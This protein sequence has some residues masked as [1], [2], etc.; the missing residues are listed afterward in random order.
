MMSFLHPTVGSADISSMNHLLI[1]AEG[2]R[3]SEMS[4]KAWDAGLS[5]DAQMRPRWI[6]TYGMLTRM[7]VF[8]VPLYHRI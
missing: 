7:F 5:I 6:A 2:Y 1:V 3:S 4:G 8:F